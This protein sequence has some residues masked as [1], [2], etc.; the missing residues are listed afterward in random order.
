M[1]RINKAAFSGL[2]FNNFEPCDVVIVNA[3]ALHQKLPAPIMDL[4]QN[5]KGLANA[6][7]AL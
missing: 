3:A 5:H 1:R 6:L 2:G 4:S 7:S